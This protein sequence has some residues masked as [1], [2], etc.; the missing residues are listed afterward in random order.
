[1]EIMLPILAILAV[2]IIA[3]FRIAQEYERAIV[4][5]LGRY[6]STKGPGPMDHSADRPPA[7]HRYPYQKQWIWSNRRPS[8]RIALPLR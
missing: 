2:I 3:G 1:M 5:R 7:N 8:Q 4:F 6:S